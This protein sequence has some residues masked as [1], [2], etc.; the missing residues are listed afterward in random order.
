[1]PNNFHYDRGAC[2]PATIWATRSVFV[3]EGGKAYRRQV[4]LGQWTPFDAEILGGLEDGAQVIVHPSNEIIDAMFVT[5][6][7]NWDP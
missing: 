4:E 6:Q 5:T 2:P 7:S 1:M 3:V